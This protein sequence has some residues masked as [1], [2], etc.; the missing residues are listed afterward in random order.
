MEKTFTFDGKPYFIKETKNGV[1]QAVK[2]YT[3]INDSV[4]YS[5]DFDND[6]GTLT[7]GLDIREVPNRGIS[8]L[9]RI[10]VTEELAWI[11]YV[12]EQ[13]RKYAS[14]TGCEYVSV[15]KFGHYTFHEISRNSSDSY[16]E[17]VP[18]LFRKIVDN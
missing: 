18:R 1:F 14:V 11:S 13:C 8:I 15:E 5:T 6:L 4:D 2:K 10:P 12:V 17:V 16:K 3:S 7:L 9:V